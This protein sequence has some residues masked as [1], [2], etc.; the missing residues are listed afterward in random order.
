MS[1]PLLQ[2]FN[3]PFDT[4]PFSKIKNEHFLPAFEE[5]IKRA[6]HEID[7]VTASKDAPTF[8]NTIVALEASGDLVDL[9]SNIFFNLNSAETSDEMQALAKDISP[10]LSEFS[11]DVMLNEQLFRKVKEV[12]ETIDKSKLDAES[13]TLLEKT[14]KGF[15]R[16][17]ANLP[18]EKKEHLRNIDKE[19]AVLGQQYGENVLKE[20]NAFSMEVTDESE[21]QGL[22]DFVKEAAAETAKEKGK[23]GS[24][25]FTLQYPSYIPFMTY[26]AN[27]ELRKKMFLAYGS[28]SFKGNEFDNQEVVKKLVQLRFERAQLLG[29]PTHAHF[30]LEERMAET[31]EKVR[32]FLE[33]ILAV[34]QPATLKDIEELSAYAKK[35]DGLDMLQRWDFA[36]YSEK[37]K[38]EK[39]EVDDELLKP[40][41]QLEK[42]I[43]GVFK[44]AEKLFGLHFIENK[45]LDRYHPD[46]LVYEVKD[47][48]ND[49]VA[50]FYADF[51]P[52]E[53]KQGGA[54]MTVFRQQKKVNGQDKR[55][56]ISIVCS[57]TKPTK[58]APSLLTF[59]EVQ[60]L[61]HEFGHALHGMLARGK[62]GSLSG[63]N[64]YWDFVELPSQILENWTL[65]K[66]CLDLFARQYKT[67]ETLP[68]EL[69]KR[70]KDSANFQAGYATTR[71]VAFGLLDMAYHGVDPS[72]ITNIGDFEKAIF[73]K[74]EVLP[75][76]KETNMT[77]QFSHIFNGGYSSG[78][79]SY[80]WAE[81]L[82]ADAFEYF[83]EKGI[84]SEEVAGKF[85]DNILS[86]GGS[87]HPMVLYKKFRGREPDPKALLRRAG[88]LKK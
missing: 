4:I 67:G 33:D 56:H 19:I 42:V 72:G 53:G 48:K 23:E 30:V 74:V 84:F 57:F 87:E 71:Q 78:Y 66:E 38:K 46:V 44:V 58:S 85:H 25:I 28:R 11:N 17:G 60:T 64:V 59:N 54:W 40:Y 18:S 1:N 39:Y 3:S 68:S 45:E 75:Q 41:F 52:R 69:V 73:E 29:Y 22:P 2:P 32:D 62:Y 51:F 24:W 14:Y 79:Y 43:A 81:V 65:E 8:E 50:I 76:I 55:P 49:Q 31:P 15:V 6:K 70:L 27:R 34:S 36:Y 35:L 86:K 16:N 7:L 63:T 21:L 20:T 47:A 10:L 77:C 26:S 9:V 82:D 5:S 88:L 61:F 13:L 80:K 37:L 12:Y 83:K